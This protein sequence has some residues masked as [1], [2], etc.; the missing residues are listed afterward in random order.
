[1]T[2]AIPYE[3]RLHPETRA[4]LRRLPGRL[5][6]GGQWTP[7]VAGHTFTTYEPST[8]RPLA[9][10]YHAEAEDVDR[11]VA[12][13]RAAFEGP[14]R[15]VTPLQR[16]RLLHRLADLIEQN[17]QQ[18]A[19][20]ETLDNGKPLSASKA[21][22]VPST[23]DMFRYF[24]GWPS[25]IEGAVKPVSIPNRL[26][27][28]VREPV[29]VVG[30]IIPWNFPLSLISWKLGPALAAGN[31]VV[32]KPA[33]QT[34]LSAIRFCELVCEA[35]FPEG[36]VNLVQGPG[37][38]T[39]AALVAHAGVDKIAFT[40]S[41]EV[42][43]LIMKAAAGNLK[44][45]SL[46]LG[47]KSPH[48]I[49]ADANV[50]Q[51]ARVAAGAIFGN[52]GQSCN[53]GSRLFVQ[54]EAYDQVVE[55]IA[56]RAAEIKV[57]PGMDANTEMGP[58]TSLEHYQ[59]VTGYLRSGLEEGAVARAG[60]SRPA[61]V[62]PDGYFV[63]PT[64]FEHV[65]DDMAI[66]REEIFGPVLVATPFDTVEEVARRANA[67]PY[68]LAAGV[69]TKDIGRAHK[70]ASLLQAGTV[71]INC[72]SQFDPSSPFGGYKQSGFGRDMGHEALE[73][74]LETKSVWVAM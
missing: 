20:I 73:Q 29:G 54:R 7:S 24:A 9:E 71:W 22:D 62:P 21:I 16:E 2:H 51:A 3:S 6:I 41:T 34:P 23:V 40:G 49:F 32:L 68:G 5:L 38:I 67:T 70:L 65:R 11:A 48:I 47:G 36:V 44:R 25:K 4:F 46:E 31:T 61:A 60:G 59:R 69:W 52:A 64:V 14:W 42:G 35:G 15:K 45:L 63:A 12:A 28:T 10:V 39:G 53:A 30:A 66:V 50:P 26:N 74:Y 1:M 58:L 17:A 19:E 72:Y 18:L 8:G 57:G 33:E 27:Y 55:I 37:E 13:A 43:R 56:N